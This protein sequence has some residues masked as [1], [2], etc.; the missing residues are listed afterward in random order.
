M[1]S[2]RWRCRQ[3]FYYEPGHARSRPRTRARPL[4]RR[5]GHSRRTGGCV[6]EVARPRSARIRFHGSRDVLARRPLS[7]FNWSRP[8]RPR[9]NC[10]FMLAFDVLGRRTLVSEIPWSPISRGSAGLFVLRVPF[11]RW[12]LS[13]ATFTINGGRTTFRINYR[14]FPTR[15]KGRTYG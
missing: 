4:R 2:A 14:Y 6:A 11:D 5:G 15:T 1:S 9:G 10:H 8:C 7:A 13:W 12:I 3:F